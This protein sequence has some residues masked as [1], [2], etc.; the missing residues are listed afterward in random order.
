MPPRRR[1][2]WACEAEA[3]R[4]GEAIH[5][6]LQ[7]CGLLR[8]AGHRAAL[9]ADPLARK[10]EPVDAPPTPTL[11]FTTSPNAA[12][13]ALRGEVRRNTRPILRPG[14]GFSRRRN[15]TRRSRRSTLAGL[16]GMGG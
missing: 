3:L 11:S 7:E 15:F 10:D 14:C 16:G 1:V 4:N 9:C 8:G 12:K 6:S 13:S 2:R 5:P